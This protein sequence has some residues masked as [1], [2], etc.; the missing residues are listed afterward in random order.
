VT[1]TSATIIDHIITNDSDHNITP[2][3][4]ISSLTD[5]YPI[6]CQI[7]NF[8]IPPKLDSDGLASLYRD[9]SKFDSENF[10]N[11]LDNKLRNF[12]H[13]HFPLSVYNFNELFNQFTSLIRDTINTR[14][15]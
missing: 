15:P 7:N 9:K 1:N 12:V 3:I 11:E 5:H 13:I 2:R 10:S 8:A 4:V 6:L 14:H